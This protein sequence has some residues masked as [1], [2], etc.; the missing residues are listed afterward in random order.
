MPGTS[1]NTAVCLEGLEQALAGDPETYRYIDLLCAGWPCQGNSTANSRRTGHAD[2]RSGLWSEVR[3]LIGIFRPQWFIG[4]NVPGLFSVN[5]GKDFWGVISDLNNFGYGVAW[6]M[7]DSRFFG[8]A[9]RRRRIF[10]VAS[11]GNIS[12]SKVLF[13]QQGNSGNASSKFAIPKVGL[14]LSTRDGERQDPSAENFV[15]SVVTASDYKR[16]PIGQFGNEGNLIAYTVSTDDRGTPQHINQEN[17]VAEID[18]KRKGAAARTPK[19]LDSMRGI[20]IGNAVTVPVVEWIGKR[21]L[22]VGDIT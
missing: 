11:F 9:Q 3:R 8:V 1:R 15:A 20:V 10:I 4:E 18:A 14:C 17:L 21:I 2:P 7:L 12:A 22:E 13:E 5:N 19:G 6:R 16:T